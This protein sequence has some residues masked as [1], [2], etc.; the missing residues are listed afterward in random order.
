MR[1]IDKMEKSTVSVKKYQQYRDLVSDLFDGGRRAPAGRAA[2]LANHLE[3]AAMTFGNPIWLWALLVLP[4][5]AFFF[6]RAEQL[7]AEKLQKFV[8]A[9]LL[10][11]TGRDGQSRPAHLAFRP[12]PPRPRASSSLAWRDRAGATPSM[13]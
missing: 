12:S 11:A 6:A 1:D 9:R 7:G 3:K 5:L 13:R 8:A 2:A 4:A 10:A